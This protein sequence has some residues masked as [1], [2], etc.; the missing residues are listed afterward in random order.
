[1]YS[2]YFFFPHFISILIFYI[3]SENSKYRMIHANKVYSSY[4][5]SDFTSYISSQHIWSSYPGRCNT[6]LTAC[7][8]LA[9][10]KK[11]AEHRFFI[12]NFSCY[13]SY[14]LEKLHCND[15]CI[16]HWFDEL[17]WE[18]NWA[19]NQSSKRRSIVHLLLP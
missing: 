18:S 9:F 8:F 4:A 1:M 19:R 10:P 15:N 14:S 11:L 6:R 13:W 17:E 7:F 2:T 5:W 12:S 3:A 16:L